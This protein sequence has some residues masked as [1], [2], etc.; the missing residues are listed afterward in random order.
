MGCGDGVGDREA[1]QITG[2]ILFEG[3]NYYMYLLASYNNLVFVSEE[4]CW[5][6]DFRGNVPLTF[7]LSPLRWR[8]M[9]CAKVEEG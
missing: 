2:P 1:V 6:K 5:Y 7:T 8:D 9:A 4:K 3:K